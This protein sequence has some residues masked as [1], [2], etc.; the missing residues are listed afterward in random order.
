MFL[1]VCV[2]FVGDLDHYA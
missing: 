1:W 2:L